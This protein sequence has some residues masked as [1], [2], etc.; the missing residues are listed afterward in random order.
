MSDTPADN[1]ENSAETIQADAD[2]TANSGANTESS[3]A[4]GS[5]PDST[6]SPTMPVEPLAR[7]VPEN[8]KRL[9]KLPVT[10]VVYLAE[11]KIEV[12]Q[13]LTISPGALIAFNKPCEDLLDL[14]VNNHRYCRGEAV[15]IGEKFGIKI[16]E[17]G[18]VDVRESP[19]LV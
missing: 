16:S 13:L 8:A 10:V 3:A 2:S 15:K 6:G 12:E 18:V 19:I 17:V 1:V 5:S 9:M 14:Y 7:T 11:K 4:E